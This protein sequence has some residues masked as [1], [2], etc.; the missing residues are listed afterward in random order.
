MT[1]SRQ[2]RGAARRQDGAVGQV[3]TT[4]LQAQQTQARDAMTLVETADRHKPTAPLRS[5]RF[6][7]RLG[8]ASTVVDL[9]MPVLYEL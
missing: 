9:G 2:R 6:F 7:K 1:R 5:V 3:L 4:R 8:I